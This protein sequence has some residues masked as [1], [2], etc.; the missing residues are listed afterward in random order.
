VPGARSSPSNDCHN[1]PILGFAAHPAVLPALAHFTR[2][3][4]FAGRKLTP[5]LVDTQPSP[6]SKA[7]AAQ[8]L[9]HAFGFKIGVSVGDALALVEEDGHIGFAT[10]T[11]AKVVRR[12]MNFMIQAVERRR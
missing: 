8:I 4:F 5:D 7:S 6:H 9:V 3:I 2:F 10:T 1:L 11:A 12:T